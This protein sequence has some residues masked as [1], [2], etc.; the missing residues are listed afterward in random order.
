MNNE[1]RLL[2]AMGNMEDRFLMEAMEYKKKKTGRVRRGII[3]AAAVATVAAMSITAVAAYENGWFGFDRIFGD[4]ATLVEQDVVSYEETEPT[5]AEITDYRFTL[6][7]MLAGRDSI[8]A[9]I[10][11]EALTEHGKQNMGMDASGDIEFYL[12]NQ[13][14]GGGLNTELLDH[15]GVAAHYLA[16]WT[17][18]EENQVGD[19]VS[20]EVYFSGENKGYSLFSQKITDIVEGEAVIELD[21]SIYDTKLEYFDKL[22]ITPL[23]MTIEGW[24]NYAYADELTEAALAGGKTKEDVD[25]RPYMEKIPK[26][27]IT[28]KDGTT[29]CLK[30]GTTDT[31]IASYGTYG[32][33]NVTGRG[34]TETGQVARSWAF[35]QV[36]DLN[37]IDYITVDGVDYALNE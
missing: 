15:D 11:M 12:I 4:K 7:S 1:Q 25:I 26:V 18:D 3:R 16:I 27:S 19:T 35:S 24:F 10:R 32:S 8:Y 29:F 22:T 31:E 20:F 34:D 9:V 33:F 23:S 28:L 13:N 37:E 5:V 30:D 21:T 2:R 14:H 17:G 36:V 6:E